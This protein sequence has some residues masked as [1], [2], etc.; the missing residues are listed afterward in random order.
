[1]RNKKTTARSTKEGIMQVVPFVRE[2]KRSRLKPAKSSGEKKETRTNS[3]ACNDTF[4]PVR[5][6]KLSG[7]GRAGPGGFPADGQFLNS[8]WG[9]AA[10]SDLSASVWI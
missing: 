4:P 8:D 7:N 6:A 3:Y 5:R 1:M 2:P 10:W 9:G